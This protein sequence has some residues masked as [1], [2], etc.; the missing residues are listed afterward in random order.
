MGFALIHRP[1]RH[2]QKEQQTKH[3]NPGIATRRTRRDRSRGRL[4][5]FEIVVDQIWYG[6]RGRDW[7][8]MTAEI[9]LLRPVGPIVD[10]VADT[11]LFR[12]GGSWRGHNDWRRDIGKCSLWNVGGEFAFYGEPVEVIRLDMHLDVTLSP[13]V[14]HPFNQRFRIDRNLLG[15]G[16]NDSIKVNAFRKRAEVTAFERRNLVQLDL[17]PLGNVLGRQP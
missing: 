6:S 11:I 2:R 1:S 4:D 16:S 14:S 13:L 3:K 9:V 7:I 17:R 5:R 10:P 15:V 8:R 12:H